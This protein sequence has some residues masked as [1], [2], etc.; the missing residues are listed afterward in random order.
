MTR[1]LGP[2]E[3]IVALETAPE[4]PAAVH[5][6]AC[7]ACRDE[8]AALR[9]SWNKLASVDVPEPSPL[10]W[11]HFSGR[12]RRATTDVAPA[13]VP[14]WS[15]RRLVWG[16]GVA[17]AALMLVVGLRW[18][19]VPPVP[20]VVDGAAEPAALEAV[21]GDELAGAFDGIALDELELFEPT[22]A[23]TWAM[24]DELTDEERSAFVRLLEQQMEA[25]P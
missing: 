6:V 22:G 7:A 24:V 19:A 8:L 1:H 14:W 4:G 21:G 16:V 13:A 15:A 12:V 10:F 11:D 18:S 5:L 20:S 2:D 3:F 23:A 25:L 9:E 17:A